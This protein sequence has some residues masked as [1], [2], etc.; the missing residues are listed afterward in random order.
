[1]AKMTLSA[2]VLSEQ[3]KIGKWMY[4]NPANICIDS[5]FGVI[6]QFLAQFDFVA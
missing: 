6:F 2:D 5:F 1:M 3:A 4:V